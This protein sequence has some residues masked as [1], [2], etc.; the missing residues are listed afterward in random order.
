MGTPCSI[1]VRISDEK[2]K[3]ITCISDGYVTWSGKILYDNYNSQEL[4]E[5]IVALGNLYTLNAVLSKSECFNRKHYSKKECESG[6]F[7]SLDE[8]L[9]A[10]RDDYIYVWKNNE[11]FVGLVARY[12]GVKKNKLIPL[13]N[14]KKDDTWKDLYNR[15][16]DNLYIPRKK[17]NKSL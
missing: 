4:A 12:H 6:I 13:V 8:A 3:S 17:N 9:D 16:T 11:W 1:I 15:E 5:S 7:D 10:Y 2:W 14:Y